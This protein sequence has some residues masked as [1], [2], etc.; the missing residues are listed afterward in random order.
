MSKDKI[1]G[2]DLIFDL[3][4]TQGDLPH[5]CTGA[6]SCPLHDGMPF[7]PVTMQEDF[8]VVNLRQTASFS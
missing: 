4:Q 7:P 6:I 1:I 5:L 8:R 3:D 2:N